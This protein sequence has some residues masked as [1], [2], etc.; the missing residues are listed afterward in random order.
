MVFKKVVSRSGIGAHLQGEI[1]QNRSTIY[2]MRR[3]L[4]E[5]KYEPTVANFYSVVP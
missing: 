4:H 5:H 2:I 1:F 3:N